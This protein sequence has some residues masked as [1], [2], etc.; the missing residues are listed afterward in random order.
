MGMTPSVATPGNIHPSDATARGNVVKCFS[1][2]SSYCSQRRSSTFLRAP[3]VLP[4]TSSDAVGLHSLVRGMCRSTRLDYFRSN[5][6]NRFGLM[7]HRA[8]L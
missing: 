8:S 4:E 1:H 3:I 2:I 7:P 6:W 5:G